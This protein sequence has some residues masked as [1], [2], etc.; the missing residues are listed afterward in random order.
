MMTS[1]SLRLARFQGELL[2]RTDFQGAASARRWSTLLLFSL[3]R[4]GP[5]LLSTDIPSHGCVRAI[6]DRLPGAI[7]SCYKHPSSGI[8]VDF[9]K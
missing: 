8:R 9:V 7:H 2:Q 6:D 4:K 3:G 5:S 1:G